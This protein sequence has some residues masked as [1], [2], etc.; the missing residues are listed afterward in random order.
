M[1][2]FVNELK[3]FAFLLRFQAQEHVPVLPTTTGLANELGFLFHRF[4]NRF[5]VRHLRRTHVGLHVELAF[6]AVHDNIQVQ[7]THT[8]NNGLA[9]F[10]IRA[11]AES[12]VFFG[13]P[14][15]S[16]GHFFFVGFRFRLHSNRDY[17]FREGDTFQ[18]NRSLRRADSL[19][20]AGVLNSHRS[21]NFPGGKFFYFFTLI[22]HHTHHTAKAFCSIFPRE[23]NGI[24]GFN[25]T[26]INAEETEFSYKRIRLHFKNK[27]A[28]RFAVRR[29]AENFFARVRVRTFDS[30]DIYRRG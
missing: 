5:A 15:Q 11:D 22:G 12:L 9:G 4:G 29:F 26:G 19:P 18:H 17:R 20:H 27:P 25:R 3:P 16:I 23:E 2:D 14:R 28:E 21:G 24:P 10:F 30:G 13:Q 7:F 6:H 1:G 8:A